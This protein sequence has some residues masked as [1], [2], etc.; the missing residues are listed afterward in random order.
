[1][2]T[3]AA[4]TSRFLAVKGFT[5]SDLIT[6]CAILTL[7]EEWLDE[8]WEVT[9]CTDSADAVAVSL[10]TE[11]GRQWST[12]H[13]RSDF[14]LPIVGFGLE[15]PEDWQWKVP[16]GHRHPPSLSALTT[17]LNQLSGKPSLEITKAERC[18]Q[19]IPE[20]NPQ[21]SVLDYLIELSDIPDIEPVSFEDVFYPHR[22]FAGLINTAMALSE[23]RGYAYNGH[24]VLISPETEEYFTTRDLENLTALCQVAVEKVFEWR[25]TDEAL[26][27]EIQRQALTPRPLE[28]L[29]WFCMLAASGGRLWHGFQLTD[30][31]RLIKWPP[32]GDLACFRKYRAIAEFMMANAANMTTISEHSGADL[33][34][35]ID[36]HNACHALGLLERKAN[37]QR[38][39][40]PLRLSLRNVY[41]SIT[42]RLSV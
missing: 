19:T 5:N 13:A 18:E 29:W 32:I 12:D 23:K 16:M 40:N 35:I 26:Q 10:S 17:L 28:E 38:T 41:Q 8:Q 33:V 15:V 6:L 4:T 31:V 25:L 20:V 2:N 30:V 36:F 1:M 11:A 9:D 37:Y 24:F 34:D 14:H 39:E 7:S 21:P 27:R 3:G 22:Y 42:K